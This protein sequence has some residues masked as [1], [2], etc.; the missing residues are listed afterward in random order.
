MHVLKQG[1]S[2]GA[3]LKRKQ[4]WNLIERQY[5]LYNQLEDPRIP[6]GNV[7]RGSDRGMLTLPLWLSCLQSLGLND[8]QCLIQWY[9][10]SQRQLKTTRKHVLSSER[11]EL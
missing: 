8:I 9:D 7:R 10:G 5:R 4:S 3:H 1:G 6:V 11:W 2:V